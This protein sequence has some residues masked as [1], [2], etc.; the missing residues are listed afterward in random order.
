MGIVM[1]YSAAANAPDAAP[2]APIKVVVVDDHPAI[3]EALATLFRRYPQ[4]Q[5]AG[6]ASNA[7]ELF[8]LLKKT[9]P[10]VLILDISLDDRHGLDLIGRI[11]VDYPQ[12]QV[13]V[14]SVFD[15]RIY[16]ERAIRAGAM[17]YIM[18]TEPTNTVIEAIQA[19]KSGEVYVSRK[20]ASQLLSK[21]VSRS[22]R[23]PN[24]TI[25][26]LT[27]RE[28]MVFQFL[29]QGYSLNEIASRLHVDRKTVEAYRRHAKEKL[30]LQSTN[31][32]L[33]FATQ[34]W[35]SRQTPPAKDEGRA[36]D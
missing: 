31:A 6:E 5:F 33:R 19:A 1:N 12:V 10:D 4:I 23:S 3:R 21:A 28:M 8:S 15:E 16:A 7:S 29:G 32:L 9:I 20:M 18:K 22:H 34:W 14:F 25:S 26:D 36:N 35:H 13:V 11:R 24:L 2:P 27:D 17:G 30:G